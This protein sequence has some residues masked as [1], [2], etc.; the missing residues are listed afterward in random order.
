[1]T[2]PLHT[3]YD[4]YLASYLVYEGAVLIDCTRL[5]PKRVEYRFVAD[6]RLHHLLRVYWSGMRVPI[7]PGDL[8]NTLRELKK[9]S[10]SW[11]LPLSASGSP[12][13]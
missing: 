3:T 7:S 9:R 6:S 13:S 1:M 2:I 4:T 10:F 11:S 12:Q 5:G 8:M